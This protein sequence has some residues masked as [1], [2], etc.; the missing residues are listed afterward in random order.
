ME[1]YQ[2]AM[3]DA[4][5]DSEGMVIANLMQSS[6]KRGAELF[7]EMLEQVPNLEALF[8]CNDDLALGAL[9]E[10]QRRGIRVPEDLSIIGFNDLDYCASAYPALSSVAIP[11]YEMA[12]RA[13]EIVLEIIRGSGSRPKPTRIDLGFEIVARD[14]T[15][16]RTRSSAR[17][18]RTARALAK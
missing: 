15:A 1:G 18:T 3:A 6:V 17:G 2:K 12:R 14:S 16:R 13:A 8:C 5:L 9:F 7:T 10:C 4:G 11:R